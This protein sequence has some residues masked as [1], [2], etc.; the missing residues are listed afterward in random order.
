MSNPT[1]DQILA[2]K[3]EAAA[4]GD[5]DM[6]TVCEFALIDIESDPGKIFNMIYAMSSAQQQAIAATNR[7]DAIDRVAEVIDARAQEETQ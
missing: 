5:T 2:L 6:A 1:R 3:A 4:A 7:G